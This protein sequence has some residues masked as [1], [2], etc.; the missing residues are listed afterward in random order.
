[1]S[2]KSLKDAECC[3]VP[4]SLPTLTLPSEVQNRPL[5]SFTP[6]PL[7]LSRKATIRP[8]SLDRLSMLKSTLITNEGM[9]ATLTFFYNAVEITLADTDPAGDVSPRISLSIF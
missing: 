9:S 8:P 3:R 5:V 1:M 6:T 7:G 2:W 4:K